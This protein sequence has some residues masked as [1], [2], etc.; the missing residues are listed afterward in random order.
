[1]D[2]GMGQVEPL[3]LGQPRFEDEM[4]A[5]Y[6]ELEQK[7]PTVPVQGPAQPQ[8]LSPPR[9]PATGVGS[10]Q[11]PASCKGDEMVASVPVATPCR[12]SSVTHGCS[13]TQGDQARSR[14]KK[15][16]GA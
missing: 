3:P 5:M 9:D 2:H 6:E 10:P 12:A 16:Y 15:R 8:V 13:A 4:N 7:L 1:M 11:P 14:M